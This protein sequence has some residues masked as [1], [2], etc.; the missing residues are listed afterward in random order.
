MIRT[1]VAGAIAGA[2]GELALNVVSYA[3]M[4]I[5]ARPASEMP[6][7][8]V[9]RLAEE[10]N[11][12]L[13]RPQHRQRTAANRQEA[14]G[15]LL[16]YVMAIGSAVAYAL[17]RRAGLRLPV[18]LAGVAVGAAA[19]AVSDSVA[20]AV[21]ATD[22]RTWGVGGWLGDIIPHAAYGVVCAATLELIDP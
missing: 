4:A 10:S 15:A 21:G 14:I 8:V 3:D 17:V 16:G 2:A 22:P 11:V 12:D 5:R 13:A 18:P 1:V 9:K 20:T 6:A 19:M 7:N